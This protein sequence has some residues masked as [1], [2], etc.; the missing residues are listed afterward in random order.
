[1]FKII[2]ENIRYGF[3]LLGDSKEAGQFFESIRKNNPNLYLLLFGGETGQG[4]ILYAIGNNTDKINFAKVLL[5]SLGVIASANSNRNTTI[6]LPQP[7]E[8]PNFTYWLPDVD[9]QKMKTVIDKCT[10]QEATIKTYCEL[11][12]NIESVSPQ[13]AKML[14]ALIEGFDLSGYATKWIYILVWIILLQTKED[15]EWRERIFKTVVV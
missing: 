4:G 8:D 2:D 1:M 13:F 14:V 11:I 7:N 15:C 6:I 5:F 10:D 3:R 12:K 9:V